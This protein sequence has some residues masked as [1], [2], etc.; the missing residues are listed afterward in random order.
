MC[1]WKKFYTFLLILLSMI[2][3][4]CIIA[5]AN[6]CPMILSSSGKNEHPYFVPNHRGNVSN[7]S[8]I[9][10]IS[11]LNNM[12][13]LGLYLYLSMYLCVCVHVYGMYILIFLNFFYPKCQIFLKAFL[14]TMEIERKCKFKLNYFF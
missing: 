2:D 9:P 4:S 10:R 8:R 3:L 5:L 1:K 11:P 13:H 12:V 7:I 14:P 6:I